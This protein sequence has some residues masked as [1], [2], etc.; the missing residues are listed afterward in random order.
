MIVQHDGEML[1]QFRDMDVPESAVAAQAGHHEER[2]SAAMRLVVELCAV[3][4][5]QLRHPVPL[6]ADCAI[7][8]RA[9]TAKLRA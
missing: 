6:L 2:W 3:A 1:R 4:K 7:A 8:L 9:G 5:F